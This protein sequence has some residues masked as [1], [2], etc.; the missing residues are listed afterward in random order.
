MV[1]EVR[2]GTDMKTSC[3]YYHVF[4][5]AAKYKNLTLAAGAL[6]NSQ[7]NV[8]R[9]IRL[10][11]HDLGCQLLIRSKNHARC[12]ASSGEKQISSS[13][14]NRVGSSCREGMFC[15]PRPLPSCQPMM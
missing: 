5:Y 11:E 7:P 12:S 9:T 1:D 8:S 3:E 14:W 6:H 4:Y 10:L 15:G 2:K 13:P